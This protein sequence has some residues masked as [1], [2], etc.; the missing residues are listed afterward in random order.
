MQGHVTP[1]YFRA[2]KFIVQSAIFFGCVPKYQTTVM[3]IAEVFAK[4]CRRALICSLLMGT[5]LHS[6]LL[7][8]SM[9]CD[10]LTW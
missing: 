1:R 9:C 6:Q 4:M 10:A 8:I 3:Y 2:N 7:F 5:R